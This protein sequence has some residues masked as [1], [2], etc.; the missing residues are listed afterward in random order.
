MK[1]LQQYNWSSCLKFWR[2]QNNL[3]WRPEVSLKCWQC[4]CLFLHEPEHCLLYM[5]RDTLESALS[6]FKSSGFLNV[7]KI[8]GSTKSCKEGWKSNDVIRQTKPVAALP[9]AKSKTQT[10]LLYHQEENH[11]ISTGLSDMEQAVFLLMHMDTWN[12]KGTKNNTK[13]KKN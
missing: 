1:V 8:R 2:L 13:K 7:M 10:H 4:F 9:C 3:P 5:T 11:C 12:A 6:E